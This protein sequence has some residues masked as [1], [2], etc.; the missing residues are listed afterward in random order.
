MAEPEQLSFIARWWQ[1]FAVG[2]ALLLLTIIV[3]VKGKQTV[4]PLSEKHI[5]NKIQL[6]QQAILLKMNERLEEH[7]EKIVM[8][9]KEI[10]R[11][12]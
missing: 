11:K 8:R 4:V 12:D 7:E 3:K 9:I 5:D 2:A 1:E 10:I 6:S